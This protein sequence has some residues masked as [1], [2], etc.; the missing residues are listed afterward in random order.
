M[1]I[2]LFLKILYF[3]LFSKKPQAYFASQKKFNP[4]LKVASETQI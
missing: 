3:E 2:N 4:K 1:N